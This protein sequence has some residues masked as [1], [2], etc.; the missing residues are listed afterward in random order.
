MRSR[1]NDDRHASLQASIHWGPGNE[2]LVGQPPPVGSARVLGQDQPRPPA[3]GDPGSQFLNQYPTGTS[4]TARHNPT[5]EL[6][7]SESPSPSPSKDY[8]VLFDLPP[9]RSGAAIPVQLGR[10]RLEGADLHLH[11]NS[12]IAPISISGLLAIA[13]FDMASRP[14]AL[15]ADALTFSPAISRNFSV[16]R[17]LSCL[18]GCVCLECN[19]TTHRLGGRNFKLPGL[20]SPSVIQSLGHSHS[21][22]DLVLSS[23]ET[24]PFFSVRENFLSIEPQQLTPCP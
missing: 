11:V 2:R 20:A 4:N 10:L 6:T 21:Q 9:C 7:Q 19:E 17:S 14:R 18:G 24:T 16:K 8:F 13:S 3:G 15:A 23:C 22:H 5:P 1:R 12:T